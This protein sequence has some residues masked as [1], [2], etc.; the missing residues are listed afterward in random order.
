[1]HVLIIFAHPEPQSFGCALLD[2]S[3]QELRANGHSVEVSDLY[4]M[5]FEPVASANDFTARRFPHALQYDR[6]QKHASQHQAFSADID[7][8]LAK[9]QRCDLLILQ[10]PLWWF[11]VPAIMKVKGWIDRV[12]VN[13]LVYGAGK[14]FDKGGM[15]GRRAMLCITTGC[16]SEMVEPDGLLGDLD[17]ILW[18]LQHGTLGYAGFEVLNPFAAWSVLY[19]SSDQR[20]SY[21]DAYGNR[22]RGIETD[23]PIPVHALEEFDE[24]WRL[25]AGVVPRTAGHR[26][27]N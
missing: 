19:A 24:G 27:P 2:R 16:T 10:F 17:V 12:F 18:H 13:G 6:E 9:L 23:V 21:L 26:R 22:L 11:S 15:R 3:V 5:D 25:K 8:E 7:T 4:A 20:Q 1:M 14:R